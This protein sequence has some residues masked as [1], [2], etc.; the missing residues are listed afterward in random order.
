L[1]A[2]L[3][4]RRV[5]VVNDVINAGSAV[6]GA[7]DDLLACGARPVVLGALM[8]LGASAG[9]LAAA[10]GVALEMLAARDHEVWSPGACPLCRAGAPLEDPARG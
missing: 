8:V 4:G 2:E 9:E 5:A 10:R 3:R 1:R 7:H 6:R